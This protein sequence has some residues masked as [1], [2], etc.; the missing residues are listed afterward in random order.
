ME[1]RDYLVLVSFTSYIMGLWV[2]YGI[3][4]QL[5][6]MSRVLSGINFLVYEMSMFLSVIA[7]TSGYYRL[8]LRLLED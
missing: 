4:Q 2:I 8:I 7:L 5:L 1:T 3:C 6:G